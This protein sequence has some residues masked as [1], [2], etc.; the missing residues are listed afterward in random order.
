LFPPA[1]IPHALIYSGYFATLAVLLT[2]LPPYLG[3]LGLSGTQIGVVLSFSPVMVLFTPMLWG[4]LADRLRRELLILRLT[5]AGAL[6]TM[7]ALF[8]AGDFWSV[9]V[10]MLLYAMFAGPVASLTDAATIGVL[11]R[12]KGDYAK[13]RLFGSAGFVIAALVAGALTDRYADRGPMVLLLGVATLALALVASFGVRDAGERQPP[14]TRADVAGLIANR[15]LRLFLFCGA[16]HWLALAPYHAFFAVHVQTLG[17]EPSVAGAGF[18]VGAGSEVVVMALY[19]RLLSGWRPVS[20]LSI[21]FAGSALRW[22]LTAHVDDPIALIAV[23]SLHG[24]SFG[25]FY[26]AALELLKRLVPSHLRATGQ[27]IF[28]AAVFGIGGG[29]GTVTSGAAFDAIGGASTFR[30]AAVVSMLAAGLV[31]RLRRST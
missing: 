18:A 2:F 5:I 23:Q 7:C 30:V 11:E 13:V 15:D 14:A 16:L 29:L 27:G 1:A 31:L 24:L 8:F 6:I 25:V 22:V 12:T 4:Y 21:A 17:L 3:R 10:A 9:A 26:V 19:R 28:F 20:L